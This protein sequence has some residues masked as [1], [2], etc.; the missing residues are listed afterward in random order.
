MELWITVALAEPC[1]PRRRADRI[2]RRAPRARD[3]NAGSIMEFTAENHR[4]ESRTPE[5]LAVPGY[6]ALA[7]RRSRCIYRSTSWCGRLCSALTCTREAVV[8]VSGGRARQP[9]T[10]RDW[11]PQRYPIWRQVPVDR[12]V[13]RA[14]H[15]L[16][17]CF[18]ECADYPP[19]DHMC[20]DGSRAR[21]GVGRA[22]R[23]VMAG[24]SDNG[25][26]LPLRTARRHPEP[27]PPGVCN[28]LPRVADL[29]SGA[30]TPGDADGGAS[31]CSSASAARTAGVPRAE[32]PG[33][34]YG[35]GEQTRTSQPR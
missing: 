10:M 29:T 6:G 17:S 31:D 1:G 30:R 7:G 2:P 4:R 19:L 24:V 28:T 21:G 9:A 18:A 33:G 34:G 3:G 23:K 20:S 5:R 26:S 27:H 22:T 13:V 15:E 11:H 14:A 16:S 32:H 8:A 12:H 35:G 25:P